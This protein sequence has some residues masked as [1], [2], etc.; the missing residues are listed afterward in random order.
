MPDL[1]HMRLGRKALKTDTRTL[2]LRTYLTSKLPPAPKSVDWTKGITDFGQMLNDQLG[3]CTIAGIG[4][5]IQIWSANAGTEC[6]LS[7]ADILDAYE[8][9]DGYDPSDPATDQGGIELD[10]LTHFKRDGLAGHELIA[11]ADPTVLNLDEVRQAI[12]LFG[13]VYIGLSL[14]ASAQTQDVWDV[15]AGSIG[16]P[17]SWG[18]HAVFVP[19]YDQM[20]FTCI[21]WGVQKTLTIPFWRKYTDEAHA[22]LS[23]DWL[24][25]TGSPVGFNRELLESDLHLIH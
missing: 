11:F 21:T 4:H 25:A 17:G 6:T 1:S 16:T 24:T 5:A 23:G 3:C 13:G 10:V 7:D 9:W 14:P 8:K 12:N 2:R 20:S 22:L 19:K 18:G 15:A